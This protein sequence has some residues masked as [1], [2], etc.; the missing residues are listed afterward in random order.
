MWRERIHWGWLPS[1]AVFGYV[2]WRESGWVAALLCAVG[3]IAL[4]L[5]VRW[6]HRND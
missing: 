4:G 6:R 5:F 2:V 3:G 1:S